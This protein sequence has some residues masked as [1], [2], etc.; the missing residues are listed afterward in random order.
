MLWA[1]WSILLW[2]LSAE[3]VEQSSD[4]ANMSA[5]PY[6][7]VSAKSLHTSLNLEV[8]YFI[9]AHKGT[10]KKAGIAS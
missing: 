7:D 2:I 4:F 6:D 1:S 3:S 8:E 5:I 10:L 9:Q